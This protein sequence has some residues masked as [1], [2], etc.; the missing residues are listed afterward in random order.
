M[1][2]SRSSELVPGV[3]LVSGWGWVEAHKGLFSP[4]VMHWPRVGSL[5]GCAWGLLGPMGVQAGQ[6][7]GHKPICGP[8]LL[9]PVDVALKADRCCAV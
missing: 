5:R 1:L 6:P 7:Q 4:V 9:G 2:L 3:L 8:V